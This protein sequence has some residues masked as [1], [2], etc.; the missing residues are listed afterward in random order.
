MEL[1]ILVGRINTR[2]LR[3]LWDRFLAQT[4][5]MMAKE[6]CVICVLDQENEFCVFPTITKSSG[7]NWCHC[8]LDCCGIDKS[9]IKSLMRK[10]ILF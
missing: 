1:K 3:G 9:L 8:K 7:L 2:H 4:W 6:H 5:L 10:R